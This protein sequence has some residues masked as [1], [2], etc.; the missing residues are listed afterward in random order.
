MR[1]APS[2]APTTDDPEQVARLEEACSAALGT[3][4]ATPY[5]GGKPPTAPSTEYLLQP[6]D[7][8]L[9]PSSPTEAD[10]L[11]PRI[12][13]PPLLNDGM[14]DKQI[15]YEVAGWWVSLCR[16]RYGDRCPGSFTFLK[17]FRALKSSPRPQ[18]IKMAPRYR[19]VIAAGEAMI[20]HG[21]SPPSWI[22]FA[23]QQWR[24]GAEKDKRRARTAATAPPPAKYALD[25]DRIIKWRGWFRRSAP[26]GGLRFPGLTEISLLRNYSAMEEE[27]RRIPRKDRTARAAEVVAAHFPDDT[28]ARTL[29]KAR[30]EN[31]KVQEIFNAMLR[32]RRW[33]WDP[34]MWRGGIGATGLAT[35]SS[36]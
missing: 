1:G 11:T 21:I 28:F 24:F 34:D 27:L 20:G 30:R 12:P 6:E 4:G 13:D 3:L 9:L 35:M 14:S 25:V 8:A 22:D 26:V 32:D 5:Q 2:Q 16:Y 7:R 17:E 18:E 31:E 10:L 19:M 29:V 15:F 23:F 36:T 33:M